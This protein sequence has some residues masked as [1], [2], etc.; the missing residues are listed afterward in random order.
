MFHQVS[1]TIFALAQRGFGTL[2]FGDVMQD[3]RDP[4]H[5]S[6]T[7]DRKVGD[8]EVPFPPIRVGV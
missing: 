6:R 1:V 8:E 7:F 4:L 3:A 5:P 2:P